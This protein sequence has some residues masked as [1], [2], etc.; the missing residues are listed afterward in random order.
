MIYLDIVVEDFL[1]SF[2]IFRRDASALIFIEIQATECPKV[3][4]RGSNAVVILFCR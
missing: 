2:L 1:E 4:E 3:L